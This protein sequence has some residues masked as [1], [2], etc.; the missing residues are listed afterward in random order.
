M[1]VVDEAI[2]VAMFS[3]QHTS[4][5]M[6]ADRIG[7]EAIGE[8]NAILRDAVNVGGLDITPVIGTQRLKR[9]VIRHD[10][11]DVEWFLSGLL[12]GWLAAGG[13]RQ[14]GQTGQKEKR[15]SLI[16]HGKRLIDYEKGGMSKWVRVIASLT[17]NPMLS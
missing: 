17:R 9:V 7:H 2:L 5:T 6:S 13:S 12:S 15:F 16:V 8:T 11:E 1:R 14:S 4:P 10:V 3:R